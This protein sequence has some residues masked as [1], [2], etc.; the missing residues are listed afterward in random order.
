MSEQA[1]AMSFWF[2]WASFLSALT[3]SAKGTPGKLDEQEIP[4]L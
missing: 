3:I 4:I 1:S 2:Y